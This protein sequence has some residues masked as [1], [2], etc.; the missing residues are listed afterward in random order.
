[1]LARL[2]ARPIA[3]MS[4]DAQARYESAERHFGD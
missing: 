3:T 1:G 2:E 4:V